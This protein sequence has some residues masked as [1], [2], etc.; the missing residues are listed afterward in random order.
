MGSPAAIFLLILALVLP[1]VSFWIL[2]TKT[3]MST[4]LAAAIAILLGWVT[5]IA[6]A[7]TALEST[8]IATTLGWV[9]P[10]ALVLITWFVY[11]NFA[12]DR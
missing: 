12:Q 11:W 6:W 10:T 9:C 5:N 1:V 7:T 3:G 8:A 4:L 2:K